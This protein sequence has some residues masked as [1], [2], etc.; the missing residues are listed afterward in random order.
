MRLAPKHLPHLMNA[1]SSVSLSCLGVC[2]QLQPEWGLLFAL[3]SFLWPCPEITLG[4]VPSILRFRR[5]ARFAPAILLCALA[6]CTPR[7]A[8]IP[9][10]PPAD[11]TPPP[12]PPHREVAILFNGEPG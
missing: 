1:W 5:A 10:A 8:A 4:P 3:K 6:G 11:T 2:R 12:P 9:P 7:R